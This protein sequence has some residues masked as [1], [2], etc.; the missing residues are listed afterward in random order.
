MSD[1]SGRAQ[2]RPPAA[3]DIAVMKVANHYQ[4]CRVLVDG[5]QL[6]PL[7][8][9]DMRSAALRLACRLATGGQRVFLFAHGSKK[10]SIEID[11][12]KLY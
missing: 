6:A 9:A 8:A 10:H 2:A 5:Y 3:G 1:E 4:V 7:E 12:A 11:C